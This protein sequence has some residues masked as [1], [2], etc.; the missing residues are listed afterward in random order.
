[1]EATGEQA[2]QTWSSWLGWGSSKTDEAK[3]GA[4]EK[5]SDAADKVKREAEKRT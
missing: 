1:V 2:K 3:R 4:A 5:T